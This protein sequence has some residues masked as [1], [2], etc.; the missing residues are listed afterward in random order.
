MS[1]SF[2]ISETASPGIQVALSGESVETDLSA[3][4]FNR[5]ENFQLFEGYVGFAFPYVRVGTG[6]NAEGDAAAGQPDEVFIGTYETSG[7]FLLWDDISIDLNFDWGSVLPSPANESDATYHVLAAAW[8]A[9]T[10][11]DLSDPALG[12]TWTISAVG[13]FIL[14]APSIGSSPIPLKPGNSGL[15]IVTGANLTLIC[16]SQPSDITVPI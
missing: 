12:F 2:V 3:A 1:N 8:A 14:F 7:K 15:K 6:L 13:R 16:P 5:V 10:Q 9:G 4:I 11:S